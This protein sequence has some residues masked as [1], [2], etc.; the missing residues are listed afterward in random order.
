MTY[1]MPRQPY[2]PSPGS[3]G[4]LIAQQ[5][6]VARVRYKLGQISP[7]TVERWNMQHGRHLA[8]FGDSNATSPPWDPD[9]K[10]DFLQELE[11]EDDV[12]GS[13]IFDTYGRGPTINH[14]MGVFGDHPS[15]PGFI[16]R[17]V[18]F[19]VSK[20]IYD[21]TS[22]ADVVSV[23][24]GGMTYQEHGGLPVPYT[25][26]GR[27]PLPP[28]R[29]LPPPTPTD[30]PYV[31]LLPQSP[32]PTAVPPT[33]TFQPLPPPSA[34]PYTPVPSPLFT[35]SDLM[36]QAQPFYPLPMSMTPTAV[37]MVQVNPY[38]QSSR[39]PVAQRVPGT[40]FSRVPMAIGHRPVPRTSTVM[41]GIVSTSLSTPPYAQ[42]PSSTT[43]KPV[44]SRSIVM[45]SSPTRSIA[46]ARALRGL[47]ATDEPPGWG[48]YLFAGLLVGGAAALFFGATKIKV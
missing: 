22:G 31:S 44:P 48:T 28:G 35:P 40:P 24:A 45:T 46:A 18:P 39:Q 29:A 42:V 23:P 32:I 8:G 30:Q 5:Q 3:A 1:G 36:P 34:T 16:D 11:H 13:G 20:D 43:S 10:T 37:P 14:E 26:Q 6:L 4:E 47:G 38:P 27:K 7:R 25:W 33:G 9:F 12:F 17:E 21:I 2:V 41:T 19:A 15:L